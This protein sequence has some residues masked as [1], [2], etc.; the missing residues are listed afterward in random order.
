MLSRDNESPDMHTK[1]DKRQS[2]NKTTD[3][4]KRT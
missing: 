2:L 4:F 3:I 1:Q